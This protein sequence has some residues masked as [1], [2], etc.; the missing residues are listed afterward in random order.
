MNT[1]TPISPQ[2]AALRLRAGKVHL[3]DIREPDEF[4][5]EHIV[6]AV[7]L[8]LSRLENAGLNVESGRD[9]VFLC[10]SGMRTQSN[11]QRLAARVDGKAFMLEGGLEAW[12]AAGLGVNADRRAPI[13]INRQVQIT[14]GLIILAGSALALVAHPAFVAIPAF[15]GAG[16]TFAGASGWCG[17]AKVLMQAPWNRAAQ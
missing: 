3:V 17:M 9:T 10:R 7:S 14:A 8:P 2:E 4:A 16:L 13:E 11:C 1:L 12:K 5:R 6:G 15:I